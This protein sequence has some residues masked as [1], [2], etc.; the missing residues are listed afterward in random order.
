MIDLSM[1]ESN[2]KEFLEKGYTIVKN[3]VDIPTVELITN[4]SL[5]QERQG[6]SLELATDN[7]EPQIHNSHSM[8]S[9]PLMESLMLKI[10]PLMEENTGLTLFPTYTYYRIYKP[11]A[12]LKKHKDRESCEISCTLCLGYEYA[13]SNYNWPIF[14]EGTPYI[15]EPGDLA[16]YRG[17]DLEHWREPMQGSENDYHVQVFLHYVDA[18]GPCAEFKYDKRPYIGYKQTDFQ[19]LADLFPRKPYITYKN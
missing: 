1:I 3:A 19:S 14:I 18:N 2:R 17:C 10:Q 8:Y 4:Y 9:D 15:L 11:G 7:S 12:D 16:I 5:I 13:D 6:L